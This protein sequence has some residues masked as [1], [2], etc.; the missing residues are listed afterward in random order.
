MTAGSETG[1]HRA[2]LQQ[3]DQAPG[4]H[5]G[6][7]YIK[8]LGASP[9]ALEQTRQAAVAVFCRSLLAGDSERPPPD[10]PQNRLQAGSTIPI[11]LK[12]ASGYWT[13]SE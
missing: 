2:P 12:Q 13:H 11:K 4:V 10:R 5:K 7:P 8:I 3:T 6:R 1:D 9:E